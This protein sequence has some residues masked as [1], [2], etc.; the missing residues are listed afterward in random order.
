MVGYVEALD[1]A[2]CQGWMD[3][4][5]GGYDDTYSLQLHP[6]RAAGQMSQMNLGR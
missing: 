3:G 6:A 1:V 5:K 2:L 4:Q